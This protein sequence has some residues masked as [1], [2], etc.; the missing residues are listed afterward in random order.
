MVITVGAPTVHPVNGFPSMGA[1]IHI[2]VLASL[3]WDFYY[4]AAKLV[5]KLTTIVILN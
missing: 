3:I 4:N 2:L 1:D 5:S